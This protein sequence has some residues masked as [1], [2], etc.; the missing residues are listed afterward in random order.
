MKTQNLFIDELIREIS[1]LN[2]AYRGAIRANKSGTE[3]LGIMWDVGELLRENRI[4]KL[5]SVAW[6]IY[7]RSPGIKRSNITRDFLSYCFRIRRF[8]RSK[9]QIKREYP[10]LSRYSLFREALPLLENPRFKLG[11][12]K[13]VNLK[14]LMNS[15]KDPRKIQEFIIRLKKQRIRISNPRT[16]RL[17][18]FKREAQHFISLYNNLKSSI[19]DQD[20]GRLQEL[21]ASLRPENSRQLAELLVSLTQ[22]GL[23]FPLF[24]LSAK[25]PSD[26]EKLWVDLSRLC[27]KSIEDRNRFR[28]LVPPSYLMSMAE[29]IST[30]HDDIELKRIRENLSQFN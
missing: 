25:M 28:R 24:I 17:T 29:M 8:F 13:L 19:L 15:S 21:R 7:G 11:K 10:S 27:D 20:E 26:W 14:K 5:H 4:A 16:Q 6:M 23:K 1:P 12:D 30:I 3:V 18:E 2:N 9:E 22:E